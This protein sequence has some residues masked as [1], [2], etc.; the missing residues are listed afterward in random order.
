MEVAQH[1]GQ[2]AHVVGVG[3]GE[4]HRVEAADAAR[5]EDLGDH[6]LADVEIL[7]G[8]MRAAAKAAA[9]DQQGLAV[10]SDQQQGI[11][12]AHVDGLHQQGVAG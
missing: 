12:L 6:L 7:R 8:L 4:G 3:V 2:A 5:P 9:I 11:A 10:G 1:G